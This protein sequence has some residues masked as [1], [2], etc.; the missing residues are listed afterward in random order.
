MLPV[1]RVVFAV[2]PGQPDFM[3][4]RTMKPTMLDALLG[5]RLRLGF[6]G[7]WLA[8]ARSRAEVNEGTTSMRL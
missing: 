1:F 4:E 3:P 8:A 7:L 6:S 5:G 2:R